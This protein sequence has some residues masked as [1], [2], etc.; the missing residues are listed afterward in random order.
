[1]VT[2]NESPR[3]VTSPVSYEQSS[4]FISSQTPCQVENTSLCGPKVYDDAVESAPE[5]GKD[6]RT[7]TNAAE[8][9]VTKTE[10]SPRGMKPWHWVLLSGAVFFATILL[11]LDNTVVAD[12][13]PRIVETFGQ[14]SKFP[15]I[16]VNY[17]LGAVGTG[18]LW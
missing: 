10:P 17:S 6:D 8:A 9:T 2:G 14:I 11:A 15:W 12:L 18:L 7:I 3:Q 4:S 13:Q 16:N 5:P 1:M